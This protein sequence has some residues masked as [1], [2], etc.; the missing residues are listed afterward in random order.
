MRTGALALALSLASGCKPGRERELPAL[1][2]PDPD[3]TIDLVLVGDVM[4]ARDVEKAAKEAAGDRYAD[5]IFADVA[6][7]LRAADVA[8]AN[9]ECVAS[10]RGSPVEKEYTMRADPVVMPAMAR[11]GF[12]VLSLANNHSLDYGEAALRDTWDATVEAA[13]L[14]VGVRFVA[15]TA[16]QQ[17]GLVHAGARTLAFVAYTE[18]FPKSFRGLHPGPF[19]L[20]EKQMRDD[21]RRARGRASHVIVSLHMGREYSLRP[22]RRQRE[23]AAA[24]FD[25]GA[26]V[27]VQHHTH[28]PQP[29]EVDLD[30]GRAVAYGLGNFV[31]DLRQPWKRYRV[32][33][34]ELLRVR[35]GDRLEEAHIEAV[36]LG[37]DH[38]PRMGGDLDVASLSRAYR[39]PGEVL[40]SL[41]G[42]LPQ[43]V[44]ERVARSGP[45]SCGTW[46]DRTRGDEHAV[47]GYFACS[48]D[49]AD[50]VGLSADL[51]A[52]RWRSVVRVVPRPDSV[53]RISVEGVPTYGTLVGF[54]GLSD[55]A[56]TEKQASPV[57]IEWTSPEGPVASVMLDQRPGWKEFS[58]PLPA[59]FTGRLTATISAVSGQRRHAGLAAWV[60]SGPAR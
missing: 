9:L 44:V 33:R 54:A 46:T 21:I 1:Q 31:F 50:A 34:G 26:T 13:M 30:L 29:L 7:V 40:W 10:R 57:L 8:F 55:W 58:V 35:L 15:S 6:P 25:A 37:D 38:R 16:A 4:P 45:A 19:P 51:S 32:R 18:V 28:T 5:H 41:E 39:P 53:V 17:P 20:D 60:V 3:G 22:T 36:T 43:A 24:A 42:A 59:S 2:R 27:V 23:I 14:P 49:P 47:D 12:D 56:A 48:K 11:A 52:G